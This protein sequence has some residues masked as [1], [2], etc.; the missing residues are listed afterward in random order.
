MGNEISGARTVLGCKIAPTF[1]TAIACTTGDKMEVLALTHGENAEE[2]QTSPIGSGDLG[3]S[4]ARRGATSP[5]ISLEKNLH[6]A[7]PEMAIHRQFFGT[8]NVSSA[9]AGSA[10]THSFIFNE[11]QNASWLTTAFELASA[12]G[13][14]AEYQSGTVTKL[15]LNAENPPN[16]TK[17]SADILSNALITTGQVNA[18][19]SLDAITMETTQRVIFQPSD[20]FLLNAQATGALT[21]PTDR[22]N[23]TSVQFEI[24]KD[25]SHVREAKGSTGNGQPVLSGTPPLN[26]MLT[27]NI[28]RNADMTWFTAMQAGT[29]YKGQLTITGPQISGAVFYKY[30][31]MLPRLKLVADVKYDLSSAAINPITLVFKGLVASAAPTGMLDVYPSVIVTN[32]RPNWQN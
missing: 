7:G 16:Y 22:I 14:V 15:G 10:F 3:P 23:V 2:L 12:T 29:E 31:L 24:T 32:L 9:G 4:D 13:A 28:A 17:M 1:G 6:F 20:E 26:W 27:V 5:T 18:I 8:E 21:S 30:V 19:T 25:Q 11:Y